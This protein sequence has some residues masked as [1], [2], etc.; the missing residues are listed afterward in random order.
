M[1]IIDLPAEGELET[2][3]STSFVQQYQPLPLKLAQTTHM[4][5]ILSAGIF[6]IFFASSVKI[7]YEAC[8]QHAWSAMN[9]IMS[10]AY[11]FPWCALGSFLPRPYI[12]KIANRSVC[13]KGERVKIILYDIHDS[14]A[15]CSVNFPFFE[16]KKQ[17][18]N[19]ESMYC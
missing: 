15:I 12:L 4:L 3:K 13:F 19:L 7:F 11:S 14:G 10:S 8:T 17:A 1:T 2:K 16:T 18:Y 9:I 5:L 6:C